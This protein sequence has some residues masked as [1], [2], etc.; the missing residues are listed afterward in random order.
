MDLRSQQTSAPGRV[1]LLGEHTDYTGG[2]VLPMAIPFATTAEL[3]AATDGYTFHSATFAGERT[4]RHDEHP[5]P[6]GD[7]S[8]YPVGVLRE[9]QALGITP[10]PF[11]LSLSGNV[12]FGAGL[13]SSASV[14]VAT[15]VALLRWANAKLS[16]PEIA[17]LCQR[18]ENRFVGSPCG[19]MDQAVITAATR[20]HALLLHTAD[21]SFELLPL[22]RGELRHA[23]IVIC[24]SEVKHSVATGTYGL[25]RQQMEAGQSIL[26]ERFPSAQNLG[27]ATV[28]Q[29]ESCREQ[30]AHESYLRCRHVI[31]ENARVR[32][33]REA[34]LSGDV[35]RMGQLMLA[36]HRSQ[37]DDLGTSCPEID[38]LVATAET[39]DGC[40]GARL[41]GGGFGGCTVNL[42]RKNAVPAFLKQLTAAYK[43]QWKIDAATYVC[44]ATDGAVAL[45]PEVLATEG[46]TR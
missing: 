27:L 19:I 3:S 4:L 24:N 33:A 1:N 15:C 23:S 44:N 42:V 7:W 30:M 41:T 16:L 39:L 36:S 40:F 5:E 25:I 17:L 35:V 18:A 45:H 29:L 6:R 28:E 37:R 14:E 11:V 10:P 46:V 8:D 31:T 2:L 13:S 22:D 26:R 9:L 43:A 12:P 21:L 38:T 32:E 20:D 34:M